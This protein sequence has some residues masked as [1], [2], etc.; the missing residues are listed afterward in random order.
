MLSINLWRLDFS[1]IVVISL[2]LLDKVKSKKQKSDFRSDSFLL[3]L[4]KHYF[5]LI[6]IQPQFKR[7][8]L[9]RWNWLDE[10]EKLFCVSN[11]GEA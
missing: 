10:P 9:W 6:S 2:N 5:Y 1:S 11:I 7:L 3:A 8:C 4:F